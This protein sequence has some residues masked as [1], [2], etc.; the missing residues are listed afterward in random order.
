MRK[1]LLVLLFVLPSIAFGFTNED[2]AKIRGRRDVFKIKPEKFAQ[3]DVTP[4]GEWLARVE[5][6]SGPK[7]LVLLKR[8]YSDPEILPLLLVPIHQLRPILD[9]AYDGHPEAEIAVH[10]ETGLTVTIWMS[11]RNARDAGLIP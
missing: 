2:L 5:M 9:S 8:K 6:A 10:P 11:L 7:Y 3:L 4:R 1:I